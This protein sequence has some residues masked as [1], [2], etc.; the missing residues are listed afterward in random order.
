MFLRHAIPRP[1]PKATEL[2]SLRKSGPHDWRTIIISWRGV[3]DGAGI[4]VAAGAAAAGAVAVAAGAVAAG[5]VAVPVEDAAG[6][7]FAPP[8]AASAD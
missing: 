2:Q 1:P 5:A 3:K 4:A 6:A 8:I 7:D